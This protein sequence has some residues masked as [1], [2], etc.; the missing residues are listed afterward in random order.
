MSA[1]YTK[2]IKIPEQFYGQSYN[3]D[4]MT[5]LVQAFNL[6]LKISVVDFFLMIIWCPEIIPV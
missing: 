1:T 6:L 4:K 5:K 2:K 3:S